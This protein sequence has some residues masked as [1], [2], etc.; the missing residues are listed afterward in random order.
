M[1]YCKWQGHFSCSSPEQIISST[2]QSVET[3]KAKKKDK[4]SEE[5]NVAS[6]PLSSGSVDPLSLHPSSD[7]LSAAL[8]DPLSQAAA[9]ATGSNAFGAKP[10]KVRYIQWVQ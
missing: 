6:D 2:F 4:K 5:A 10:E 1:T 3:V 8:L 9:E 7:P